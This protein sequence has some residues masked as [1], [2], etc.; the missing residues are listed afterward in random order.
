[1]FVQQLPLDEAADAAGVG[2][3]FRVVGDDDD[4][5]LKVFVQPGQQVHDFP[6]GFPVQVAGGLIRGDEGG[7]GDQGP[8]DGHPLLLAAGELARVV[9]LAVAQVHQF[10][11]QVHVL[12]SLPPGQPG[13][14]Q[15]Q[16]HVFKG[17]EHR[18]ELIKLEDEAHVGGPPIRQLGLGEG[19]EVDA[20]H[21]EV[22]GVRA[23]QPGD[24]VEQRGFPG[25]GRAHEGQ[26]FPGLDGEADVLED[27]QHLAAPPIG[28]IQVGDL[29]HRG[30]GERRVLRS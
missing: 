13:E 11:D 16:F 6:G 12:L 1:M 9:V 18:D 19:R 3:G 20:V 21:R 10:Q 14:Q 27:R 28:F 29:H 2:C 8:G 23:V 7:V 22:A 4:G 26:K 17:R 30:R 15:G 25:A 24:E 5:L